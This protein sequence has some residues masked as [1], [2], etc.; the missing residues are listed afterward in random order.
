M[1]GLTPQ[2]G[3]V[4]RFVFMVLFLSGCEMPE[5]DRRKFGLVVRAERHIEALARDPGTIEYRNVRYNAASQVICGEFNGRNAF[6]GMAGFTRYVY[7]GGVL[8]IEGADENFE[9]ASIECIG[10]RPVYE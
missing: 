4:K 10:A 9:I 7:R 2:N 6:G 3:G 1:G 5:E 8:S